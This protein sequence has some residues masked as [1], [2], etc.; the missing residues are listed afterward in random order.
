MSMTECMT[1][2]VAPNTERP[3][4]EALGETTSWGRRRVGRALAA[5]SSAPLRRRDTA[6]VD[7]PFEP[8]P[9]TDGAY[10][11][12]SAD[13]PTTCRLHCARSAG[14]RRRLPVRR[15]PDARLA[16]GAGVDHERLRAQRNQPV[17][18]VRDLIPFTQRPIRATPG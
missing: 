16:Q 1:R 14:S 15:R 5:P 13:R 17:A 12:S 7:P 3:A 8:E 9:K 4:A 2:D 6:L 18:H 11:R 10:A